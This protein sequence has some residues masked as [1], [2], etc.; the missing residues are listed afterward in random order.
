MLVSLYKYIYFFNN[1]FSLVS[2]LSSYNNY[3][4]INHRLQ[5]SNKYYSYYQRI[6]NWSINYKLSNIKYLICHVL[7]KTIGNINLFN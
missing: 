7:I 4:R 3:S 5:L 6:I 2:A 1:F